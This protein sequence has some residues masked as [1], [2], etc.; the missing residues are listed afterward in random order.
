[1]RWVRGILW[2]HLFVRGSGPKAVPPLTTMILDSVRYCSIGDMR[3]ENCGFKSRE[4]EL[5]RALVE[6]AELVLNFL[7]MI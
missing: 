6:I 5:N 7:R 3:R 4:L 2:E 1:M